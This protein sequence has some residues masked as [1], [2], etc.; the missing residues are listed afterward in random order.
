MN[1]SN[2][3]SSKAPLFENPKSDLNNFVLVKRF[4]PLIHDKQTARDWP[5]AAETKTTALFSRYATGFIYK[6]GL[7]SD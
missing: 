1:N 2:T 3:Q 6:I 4:A 7:K 5:I